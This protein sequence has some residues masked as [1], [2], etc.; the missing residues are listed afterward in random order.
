ME[1]QITDKF[2]I[3]TPLAPRLDE[4]ECSRL[5]EEF[6]SYKNYEIGLDLSFVQDCTI[7]FVDMIESYAQQKNIGLFNI[8]SDLFTIFNFMNMDK[9]LNLFVSESDF[10]HNKHRLLNRRFSFV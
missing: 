1:I 3:L 5:F 8:A 9:R 7:E 2:C 4:H 6:E 10:K